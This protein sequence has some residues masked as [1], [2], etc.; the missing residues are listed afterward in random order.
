MKYEHLT[1]YDIFVYALIYALIYLCTCV[2]E[3]KSSLHEVTNIDFWQIWH[4]DVKGTGWVG[5]ELRII[6]MQTMGR[7][8]MWVTPYTAILILAKLQYFM[9]KDKSTKTL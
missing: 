6:L 5:L 2:K 7:F 3:R 4:F 8:T 9:S 1:L